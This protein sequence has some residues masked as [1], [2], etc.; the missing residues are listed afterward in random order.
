MASY[1]VNNTVITELADLDDF[2]NYTEIKKALSIVSFC[3]ENK[4]KPQ[5]IG[6][7]S[8]SVFTKWEWLSIDYHRLL[9]PHLWDLVSVNW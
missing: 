7:S 9:P 2:P 8:Q 3:N 6:I 5:A 1:Q 4:T